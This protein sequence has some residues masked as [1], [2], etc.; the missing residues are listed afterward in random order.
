MVGALATSLVAIY[1]LILFVKSKLSVLPATSTSGLNKLCADCRESNFNCK[2]IYKRLFSSNGQQQLERDTSN[3][4]KRTARNLRCSRCGVDLPPSEQQNKR[5]ENSYG[6]VENQKQQSYAE[7]LKTAT[8]GGGGAT[9]DGTTSEVIKVGTHNHQRR[10]SLCTGMTFDPDAVSVSAE[11]IGS[12]EE[13]EN[14]TREKEEEKLATRG[15]KKSHNHLLVPQL[16]QSSD[17]TSFQTV[18]ELPPDEEPPVG[19]SENKGND[20]EMSTSENVESDE[21]KGA[22]NEKFVSL[23][24]G[25]M[26]A[27]QVVGLMK[28]RV[29]AASSQGQRWIQNSVSS[30]SSSSPSLSSPFKS[31]VGATGSKGAAAAVDEPEFINSRKLRTAEIQM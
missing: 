10:S 27:K 8:S 31:S 25:L 3:K 13:E 5:N 16:S 28:N 9:L 1:S 23:T 14:N 24:R 11:P 19:A 4:T 30:S 21:K 15:E 7:V 22:E 12:E 20:C 18:V 29:R 17:L 26:R 2:L 6:K